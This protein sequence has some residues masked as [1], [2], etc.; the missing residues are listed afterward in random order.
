MATVIRQRSGL[1]TLRKA[2]YATCQA[3]VKFGPYLKLFFADR[4]SLVAAIDGVSGACSVLIEEIDE[5]KAAI[6]P[7]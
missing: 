5:A 7:P 4:P 2:A 6:Y 1:Y 3:V